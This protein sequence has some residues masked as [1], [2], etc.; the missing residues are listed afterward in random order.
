MVLK[1]LTGPEL[2]KK[3]FPKISPTML[4]RLAEL[5]GTAANAV[6]KNDHNAAVE[7]W[8]GE[9]ERQSRRLFSEVK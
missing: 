8:I 5:C 3:K 1:T 2:E 6:E 7:F 4:R 9:V